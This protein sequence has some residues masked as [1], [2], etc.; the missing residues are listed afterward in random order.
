MLRKV[1]VIAAAL[2]CLAGPALAA[3]A[4]PVH[5]REMTWGF[6]GPFGKFDQGQLQRGA[7]VYLEVC[8]GCH[9]A[10]LLAYRTLAEKGGPFWNPEFPNPNDNP[11]VKSIASQVDVN[12]I[13]SETGDVIQRPATP[14]DKFRRP[15][16]NDDAARAGNGGALP[17]DLSVIAKARHLGPRYIYSL[18]VGYTKAPVG[19]DMSQLKV[20]NGQYYNPYMPGDVSAAW[21]GD[22]HHVPPGGFLAMPPPL[23]K[24][25]VTFDDGKPSTVDQQAK[26]V[27]AFLAWASDPKATERKQTGF[28]VM[29]Y[30]LILAG[31]TYASYRRVWRGQSH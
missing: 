17:P 14:A 21:T 9:S 11:V 28:F 15:Y 20:P 16:P 18:L 5:P 13:D 31:L 27:A 23:T 4:G 30:L 26:D 25:K 12:D 7:K 3:G 22:K 1:S 2:A 24:D 6:E 8:S 29:I 10:D 19:Y